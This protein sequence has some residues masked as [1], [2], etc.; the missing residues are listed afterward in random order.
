MDPLEDTADEA[1]LASQLEEILADPKI[2][3]NWPAEEQVRIIAGQMLHSPL[4]RGSIGD[5][6]IPPNLDQ[7]LP[8]M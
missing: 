2:F 4:M 3:A 1:E 8:G 6:T 7:L 5:P